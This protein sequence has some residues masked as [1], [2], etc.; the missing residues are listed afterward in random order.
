M[1]ETLLENWHCCR[2]QKKSDLR[3]TASCIAGEQTT[4]ISIGKADYRH[5]LLDK[6]HNDII[7]RIEFIKSLS[8]FQGEPWIKLIPFASSLEIKSFKVGE[9][10]IQQG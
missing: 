3:R 6:M 9:T 1:M 5:I 10:V 4:V 8:F 7:S 2:I